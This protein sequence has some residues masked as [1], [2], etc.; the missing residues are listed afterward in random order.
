[1]LLCKI[2]VGPVFFP[3]I[4][5]KLK[6]IFSPRV[7]FPARLVFCLFV[8]SFACLFIC[9]SACSFIC[10]FVCVIVRA[11]ICQLSPRSTEAMSCHPFFSTWISLSFPVQFSFWGQ[12]PQIQ[13]SF[14]LPFHFWSDSNLLDPALHLIQ[15]LLLHIINTTFHT[16]D[17]ENMNKGIRLFDCGMIGYQSNYIGGRGLAWLI[18]QTS[19]IYNLPFCNSSMYREKNMLH[20]IKMLSNDI[21]FAIWRNT[22]WYPM[23]YK[24]LSKEINLLS[25]EIHLICTVVQ[26]GWVGA[27]GCSPLRSWWA[28]TIQ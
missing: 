22:I 24:S 28:C 17:M 23:K 4:F 12:F 20:A 6:Y 2:I 9:L 27:L 26:G 11:T 13:S 14:S 18:L 19:G 5:V 25:K 16:K 8:Y 7:L 1:M 10:V 15:Q 3:S 21:Q